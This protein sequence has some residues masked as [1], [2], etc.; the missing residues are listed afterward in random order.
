VIRDDALI[1]A[2]RSDDHLVVNIDLAPTF[3]ALAGVKAPNADGRSLL[4]LITSTDGP[5][6]HDFLM[7][8]LNLN[9]DPGSPTYC[10]VHTDRYVYVDYKT[11]EEELYDLARDPYELRN[12]ARSAGYRDVLTKLRS[13]LK[14]LCRP[15]PPGFTLS[16]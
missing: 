7:E 16:Y 15:A 3:A 1:D 5:W 14:E 6:R 12:Q 9:D 11:G 13:R 8:L 10:G 2:P 4:P